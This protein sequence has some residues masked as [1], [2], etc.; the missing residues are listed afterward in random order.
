[1]IT[2]KQTDGKTINNTGKQERFAVLRII[3][4]LQMSQY[5]IPLVVA[6]ATFMQITPTC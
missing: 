1:M 4:V 2:P 3:A 6:A 5:R